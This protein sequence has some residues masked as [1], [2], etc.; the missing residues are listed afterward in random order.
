[1]DLGK[2]LR[3]FRVV[4]NIRSSWISSGAI[5]DLI[6]VVCGALLLL[7]Y[8]T[9]AD[10]QPFAELLWTN[11]SK[12]E[13][14]LSWVVGLAALFLIVYPGLELSSSRSIPF[15]STI[16]IPFQFLGSALASAAGLAWLVSFVNYS[17]NLSYVTAIVIL[18]AILATLIFSFIH[19]ESAR[20][21]KG[22]AR[23]SAEKLMKGSLAPHFVWG[24]LVL[25]LIVPALLLLGF[26]GHVIPIEYLPIAGALLLVGNFL[27]KYTLLKAAYYAPLL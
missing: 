27:A 1:V 3:F 4:R 16:L 9:I 2:P 13:L 6:F 19:I 10:R 18:I 7:P 21:Q 23:M 17:V 26:L 24:N 11:G 20:S 5:A 22:A 25:G 14:I 15:W 12:V 8:L